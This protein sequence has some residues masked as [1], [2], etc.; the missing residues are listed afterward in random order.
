VHSLSRV[1]V[2][3]AAAA[4]AAAAWRACPPR[5]YGTRAAPGFERPGRITGMRK[6][7]ARRG[8]SGWHE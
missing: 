1:C 2:A 7:R 5:R 6:E 8:G 4:A 3:V